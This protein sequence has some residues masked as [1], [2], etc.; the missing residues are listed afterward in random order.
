MS[1]T[2]SNSRARG[3]AASR[4]SAAAGTRSRSTPTEH[5]TTTCSSSVVAPN[6][7]GRRGILQVLARQ[8]SARSPRGGGRRPEP[9]SRTIVLRSHR[10]GARRAS[11]CVRSPA[12]RCWRTCVT[13]PPSASRRRHVAVHHGE[14]LA[15]VAAHPDFDASVFVARPR[16]VPPRARRSRRGPRRARSRCR[17]PRRAACRRDRVLAPAAERA[18]GIGAGSARVSVVPSTCHTV[19]RMRSKH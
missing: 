12:R 5:A 18:S 17:A 2:A 10:S 7:H 9:G 19:D 8:R 14:R 16:R 11:G 15:V 13:T 4:A 3:A 1:G 6:G